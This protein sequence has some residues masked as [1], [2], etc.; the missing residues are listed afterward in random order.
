MINLRRHTSRES[1]PNEPF[2][3]GT[4]GA[5]PKSKDADIP[6]HAT[7]SSA[8]EPTSVSTPVLPTGISPGKRIQ[9]RSQ[10]MQQLETWHSLYEKGAIELE[11]YKNVQDTF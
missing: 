3:R 6:T 4:K 8:A 2:F 9:L 7:S 11:E 5:K 10:S 1:A